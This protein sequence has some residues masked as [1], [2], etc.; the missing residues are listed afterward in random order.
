[1]GF[2][3]KQ[4]E[5]TKI[6]NWWLNLFIPYD[7]LEVL[8]LPEDRNH[9]KKMMKARSKPTSLATTIFTSLLKCLWAT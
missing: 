4:K 2:E 9:P 8:L 7:E 5:D 1:M 3:L 6:T